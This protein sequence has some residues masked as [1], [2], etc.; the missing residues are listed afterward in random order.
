[1]RIDDNHMYHGAALIQV[2]EDPRF[3]AINA[4]PINND[5]NRAAYLI[6]QDTALYL[7]YCSEPSKTEYREYAFNFREIH[8]DELVRISDIYRTFI[9]LVCVSDRHVCCIKYNQLLDLVNRR[10]NSKGENESQYIVL[11][12][13]HHGQQFRVYVNSPGRRG[14]RIGAPLLIPRKSFPD[15]LFER[16]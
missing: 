14:K 12:T 8:I 13:A 2:A 15:V 7:K 3:T 9:G 6:N 11:V 4:L 1:M 16:P 5:I 10:R